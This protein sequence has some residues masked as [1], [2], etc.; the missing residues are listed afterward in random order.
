MTKGASSRRG[1]RSHTNADHTGKTSQARPRSGANW[2]TLRHM[3]SDQIRHGIT[4]NPDVH[5]T[6]ERFWKNAKV[7]WPTR[8]TIV[9][10]RFDADLLAWFRQQ[11]GYQTRINAILRAYMNAIV[12]TS[13]EPTTAAEIRAYRQGMAAYRR[14]D[15]VTLETNLDGMDNRPRRGRKKSSLN[16]GKALR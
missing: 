3:S 15:Y 5:P 4:S 6:D 1:V 16:R 2:S 10:M 12:A 8:K 9:T 14:G 13:A 7:I 11:R